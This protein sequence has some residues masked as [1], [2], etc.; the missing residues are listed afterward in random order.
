[1]VGFCKAAFVD[2]IIERFPYLTD[3]TRAEEKSGA[4]VAKCADG[5]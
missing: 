5:H 3:L 4:A 1:M 2:M